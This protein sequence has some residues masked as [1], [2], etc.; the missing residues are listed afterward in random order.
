MSWYDAYMVY[1]LL[2]ETLMLFPT[3]RWLRWDGISLYNG[4][5]GKQKAELLETVL[6]HS[7]TSNNVQ[8][9]LS[10]PHMSVVDNDITYMLRIWHKR[11]E[12][13]PRLRLQPSS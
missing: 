8:L 12:Q 10:E 7:V 3:V 13:D 6:I 9:L 2:G 5:G 4:I 11:I 1:N